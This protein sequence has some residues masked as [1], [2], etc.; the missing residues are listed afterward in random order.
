MSGSGSSGG[1]GGGA[2]SGGGAGGAAGTVDCTNIFQETTLASPV[3]EVLQRL[4]VNQ[5][6]N[7]QMQPPRGPLL[8]VTD[9]GETAGS[10]TT[11]LLARLITC[12]N[13]G[14]QYVAIVRAVNGGKCDVE[15]R[16]AGMP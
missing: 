6:L 16:H 9:Q 1:G 12:I 5:I 14:H 7:L 13:D 4:I 11:T 8:A 2:S 10:I 15:I 3:P